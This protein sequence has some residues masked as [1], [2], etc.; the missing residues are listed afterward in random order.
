MWVL[1]FFLKFVESEIFFQVSKYFPKAPKKNPGALFF[2]FVVLWVGLGGRQ[3]DPPPPLPTSSSPSGGAR[4]CGRRRLGMVGWGSQ[5]TEGRS[6][7][8]GWLG[9]LHQRGPPLPLAR[10]Q[11]M[12]GSPIGEL[13]KSLFLQ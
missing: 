6:A 7:F 11:A 12:K 9:K 1:F 8:S 13:F 2:F 4:L 10:E 3:P 5:R